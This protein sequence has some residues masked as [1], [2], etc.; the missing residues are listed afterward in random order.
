MYNVKI[1]LENVAFTLLMAVAPDNSPELNTTFEPD[2]NCI[3]K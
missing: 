2:G 3:I 1:L